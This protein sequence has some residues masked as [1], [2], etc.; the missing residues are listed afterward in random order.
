MKQK[1]NM[2]RAESKLNASTM[3]FFL[4]ERLQQEEMQEKQLLRA[5]LM[6]KSDLL[7]FNSLNA[8]HCFQFPATVLTNDSFCDCIFGHLML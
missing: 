1:Q 5:V 4:A 2:L 7:S 6:S 8:H 3:R